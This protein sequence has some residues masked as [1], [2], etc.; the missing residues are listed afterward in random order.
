MDIS[1]YD[2]LSKHVKWLHKMKRE[3]RDIYTKKVT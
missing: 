3:V 2:V 1:S